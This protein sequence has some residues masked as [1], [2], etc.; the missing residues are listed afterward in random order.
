M[1]TRLNAIRTAHSSE[2]DETHHQHEHCI[3]SAS[4]FSSK[5][6]D[7]ILKLELPPVVV[8]VTRLSLKPLDR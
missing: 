6:V 8:H 3:D 7:S 1:T 2:Y 5:G 4:H